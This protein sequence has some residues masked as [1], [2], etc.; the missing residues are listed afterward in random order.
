MVTRCIGRGRRRSHHL[1]PYLEGQES[2]KAR[3]IPVVIFNCLE[4]IA[5]G[6]LEYIIIPSIPNTR[7]LVF[8]THVCRL[9]S[10]VLRIHESTPHLNYSDTPVCMSGIITP[11]YRIPIIKYIF[12]FLQHPV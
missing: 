11:E 8:C 9:L 4:K 3:E 2:I 7:S 6:S 5:I 1:F 12:I 10:G